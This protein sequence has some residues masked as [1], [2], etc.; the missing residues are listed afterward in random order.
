[1]KFTLPDSVADPAEQV[2]ADGLGYAIASL[3]RQDDPLRKLLDPEFLE[4][5]WEYEH[6]RT[7]PLIP[8]SLHA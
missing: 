8:G 7:E 5:L 4:V 1:M 2:L 3:T 6:S